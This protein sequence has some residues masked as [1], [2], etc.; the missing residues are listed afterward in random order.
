MEFGVHKDVLCAISSRFLDDIGAAEFARDVADAIDGHDAPANTQEMKLPTVHVNARAAVLAP[1]LRLCYPRMETP[2]LYDL[3]IVADLLCLAEKYHTDAVTREVERLWEVEA[4]MDP[5]CA[6]CV[7]VTRGL[8]ERAQDAA[9]DSLD[10]SPDGVY[11]PELEDTPALAYHRLLTYHASCRAAATGLLERRFPRDPERPASGTL[12]AGP[13]VHTPAPPP[14]A[15]EPASAGGSDV[16]LCG[17]EHGGFRSST[18]KLWLCKYVSKMCLEA[19]SQPYGVEHNVASIL[20]GTIASGF[21]CPTCKNRSRDLAKVCN[22][23]REI[24][25]Q[26]STATLEI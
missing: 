18:K 4:K 1:F 19:R 8:R 3:H 25:E 14:R 2:S 5:F 15:P 9:K 22:S 6:Y 26:V 11:I 20:D 24:S 21:W 13:A 23:L 16:S 7:A 17:H 12:T 10:K